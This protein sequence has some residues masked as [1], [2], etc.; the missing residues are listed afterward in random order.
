MLENKTTR[1]CLIENLNV[2]KDI[3]TSLRR[4]VWV[5]K[6]QSKYKQLCELVRTEGG[7]D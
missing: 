3:F 4:V 2:S 1:L 5:L 6:L 7:G